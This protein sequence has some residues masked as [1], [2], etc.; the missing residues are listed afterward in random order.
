MKQRLMILLTLLA[1]PSLPLQAQTSDTILPNPNAVLLRKIWM[2]QGEAIG[3]NASPGVGDGAGN[4]GDLSSDSLTDFAVRIQRA[5]QWRIYHGASPA[6]NTTPVWTFD[7]SSGSLLYPV[8]GTFFDSQQRYLVLAEDTCQFSPSTFCFFR[9]VFFSISNEGAIADT[10]S[11]TL[12]TGIQFC[13]RG[14]FACDLDNDGDDELVLTRSCSF[15]EIWFYEGGSTFSTSAPTMKLGD[16]DD[17]GSGGGFDHSTVIADVDGDHRLDMVT[18]AGY[19]GNP[20]L[21]IWYG[22]EGSPWNWNSTPDRVIALDT[23]IGINT[24]LTYADYDGDGKLDFAGQVWVGPQAGVYVYLSRP[25]KSFRSRSFSRDDADRVFLSTTY[26]LRGPLGPLNDPTHTFDMLSV[27][28][29]DPGLLAFSGSKNG[30]DLHNEAWYSEAVVA[31]IFYKMHP[32]SD[33]NGDGWSDVLVNDPKWWG[34]DQGIAVILAGGPYIPHDDPTVDVQE[35]PAEGKSNAISIWPNP[36]CDRLNIAWHGRLQ[37]SPARMTIHDLTG[38][39]VASG[40][41]DP[42]VGAAL[43]NA[44]GVASGGYILTVY[45]AEGRVIA[46]TRFIKQE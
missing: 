26:F 32:L 11:V 18:G 36:V 37:H 22:R 15:P 12:N 41:T 29:V 46:S 14:V 27:I 42:S 13:P 16:P 44:G 21:K 34:F 28:G 33:C 45:D 20:K 2:I 23:S 40:A 25:G 43:W 35:L 6:P 5:G 4:L 38:R 31:N 10:P 19:G 1:L 3:P 30:P 9:L 24:P 8:I 39:L 17:N 7:S